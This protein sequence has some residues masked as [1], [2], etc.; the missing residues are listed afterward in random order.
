MSAA[1]IIS[2]PHEVVNSGIDAWQ[3]GERTQ[4]SKRDQ[5]AT[6]SNVSK[7]TITAYLPGAS[8]AN[9]TA[10]I[11]AP[12]GG[13]HLLSIENE[14]IHV[15]QWCAENGIAAFVL[16]YRLVPT[17]EDPDKEFSDK[18]SRSQEKMDS[19]IAP[20]IEL[21]KADALEAIAHVRANANMYHV[22][23]DKIGI[24]GFSAGGTLAAA[25]GL[26]YTSNVNRPNFIA[27]I[28][29]ALHLLDLTKFLPNPCHSFWL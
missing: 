1:E 8:K 26:E 5:L 28:Y 24:V 3:G 19:N 23:T 22:A 15:A 21:A 11:I 4:I 9:G 18:I 25:T 14:G 27:P 13:F 20:Y 10:I 2:L 7:P 6:V 16:K 29:G 12:G 17:G